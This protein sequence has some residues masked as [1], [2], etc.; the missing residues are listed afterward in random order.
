MNGF[1][2]VD[3]TLPK[4]DRYNLLLLIA[5]L[6]L[7]VSCAGAK[8]PILFDPMQPSPAIPLPVAQ[9]QDIGLEDEFDDFS[10]E[11][12][13]LPD[14]KVYDPFSGYNRSMTSFNDKVFDWII[15]PVS[16]GY[17][18]IVPKGGRVAINRFFKNLFFP[19]RF[20]NNVLQLKYDKAV[21]ETLRFTM[22]TT[23][24]LLGFFD[25]AESWLNLE[26]YPEDFGQTLG[27]YGFGSGPHIVLPFLGPS[28]LRDFVGLVPDIY[29]TPLTY[30]P[31][32]GLAFGVESYRR[33]NIAS[34]QLEEY[35]SLR[36]DALD[37]Y[38]FLRDAY[39][40]NRTAKIKE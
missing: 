12:E 34:L 18:F 19:I 2:L 16:R 5:I 17:N 1:D 32:T 8:K 33:L 27:F 40:R 36:R 6:L 22:N 35:K 38:T 13:P 25:P 21:I 20:V 4:N 3:I 9:S 31:D 29:A 37:L 24:G 15:D 11:F 30:I 23:V 10:D 39:E 28:N 26:A 14:Q 7:M